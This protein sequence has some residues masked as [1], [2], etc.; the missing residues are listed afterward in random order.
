M[1]LLVESASQMA[2][3]KPFTIFSLDVTAWPSESTLLAIMPY[4]STCTLKSA[5]PTTFLA[6][7]TGTYMSQRRL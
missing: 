3:T 2:A 6:E 7:T 1:T 4:A 5:K